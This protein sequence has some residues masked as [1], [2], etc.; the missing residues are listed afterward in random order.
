MTL[1]GSSL[2]FAF[3]RVLGGQHSALRSFL[4]ILAGEL[5]AL[6]RVFL[7]FD[8]VA[9][10]IPHPG[11]AGPV[12]A[13]LAAGDGDLTRLQQRDVGV[14]MLHLETKMIVPREPGIAR[15][16]E[17]FQRLGG[18]TPAVGVG[19]IEN[20]QEGAP[21]K[22]E[23]GAD[24]GPVRAEIAKLNG[25]AQSVAVKYGHP[26]QLAGLETQVGDLSDHASFV[27]DSGAGA[28][29]KFGAMREENHPDMF[30]AGTTQSE[31]TTKHTKHTKRNLKSGG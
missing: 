28:I 18:L 30:A 15:V 3:I 20:F 17:R 23:I 25:R 16:F 8:Q 14:E 4:I 24:R 7:K 31:V 27:A 29:Q 9:V 11:L 12:V 1:R 10:G 6:G 22:S 2:G 26:V 21:A 13:D 5:P 19:V